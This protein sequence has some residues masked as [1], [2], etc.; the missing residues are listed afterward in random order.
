MGQDPPNQFL[1]VDLSWLTSFAL[2]PPAAE[3]PPRWEIV[4]C[5]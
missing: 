1:E 5:D 4:A 2:M 3:A